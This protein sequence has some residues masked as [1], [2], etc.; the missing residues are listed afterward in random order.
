MVLIFSSK[1]N[2]YVF[3]G[4]FLRS[5]LGVGEF[6][7][8][9]LKGYKSDPFYFSSDINLLFLGGNLII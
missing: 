5:S 7:W 4:D 9:I 3:L 2:S 1:L 8:E 6:V